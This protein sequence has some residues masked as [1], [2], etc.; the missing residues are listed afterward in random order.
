[1]TAFLA[2][3]AKLA[4]LG[5]ELKPSTRIDGDATHFDP[6]RRKLDI[7]G[8]QTQLIRTMTRDLLKSG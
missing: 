8:T 7:K 2:E 4:Q 3:M 6:M 5:N 1:M